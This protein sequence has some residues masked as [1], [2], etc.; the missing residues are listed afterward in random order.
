MDAF[1]AS[2]LIILKT[3]WGGAMEPWRPWGYVSLTTFQ[4]VIVLKGI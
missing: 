3:T 1:E 4:T 2:E